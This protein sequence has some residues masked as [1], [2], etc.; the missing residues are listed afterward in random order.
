MQSI[1]DRLHYVRIAILVGVILAGGT[2]FYST[3][4]L[5]QDAAPAN[6]A[7]L[8]DDEILTYRWQ[9]TA[10][11]YAGQP[12]LFDLTT[13]NDGDISAYRWEATAQY[14]AVQPTLADLT[15]LS[16]AD[17]STYRWA[18]MAQYSCCTAH[19]RRSDHIE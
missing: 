14:Y 16:D 13:L 5:A 10:A 4:I 8:S 2:G 12:A 7:T 1:R 19:L 15:T 3:R 11:F 9:A 17:I 18:A 6:L